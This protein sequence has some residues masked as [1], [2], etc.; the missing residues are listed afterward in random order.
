M[1][2]RKLWVLVTVPGLADVTGLLLAFWAGVGV[3]LKGDCGPA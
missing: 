3:A 2:G 1:N